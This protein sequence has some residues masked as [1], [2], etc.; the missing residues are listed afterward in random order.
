MKDQKQKYRPSNGSEGMAFQEKFCESCIHEKFIHTAADGDKQC[1]ILSRSMIYDV[2]DFDYP[3]EW[4]YD[5]HDRPT[6]TKFY[7]WDWGNVEDGLN[8][9]DENEIPVEDPDQLKLFDF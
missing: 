6:C 1:D 3:E 7:R 5:R 8:E 4:I 2:E 9:P